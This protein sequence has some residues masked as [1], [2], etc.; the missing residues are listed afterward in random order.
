MCIIKFNRLNINYL[1][2]KIF[3]KMEQTS[4]KHYHLLWTLKNLKICFYIYKI[5]NG[6]LKY[7]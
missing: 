6:Q 2:K 5:I 1:M 3:S 4:Y 7:K